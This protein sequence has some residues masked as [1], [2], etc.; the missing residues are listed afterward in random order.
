MRGTRIAALCAALLLASGCGIRSTDVVEVGDP[1]FAK[2]VPTGDEATTLYFK[3]PGGLLPV[4]RSGGHKESMLGDSLI[5]LLIGPS[6]AEKDAGLT[7][8]LPNYYGGL[9]IG[10][11]GEKVT[12]RLERAVL[13]FPP[14]ARQQLACTAA[15]AVPKGQA[16]KVTVFGTDGRLDLPGCPF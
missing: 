10:R 5:R 2:V 12:V 15:H 7:S 9:A 16:V 13:D 4:V 11:E 1:A 6:D 14:L 3:G 8:E